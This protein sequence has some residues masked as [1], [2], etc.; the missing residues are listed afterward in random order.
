[1]TRGVA[2]LTAVVVAL[3][4]AIERANSLVRRVSR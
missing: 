4:I 2:T 1:M 3:A